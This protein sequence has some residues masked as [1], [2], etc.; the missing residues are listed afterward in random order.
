MK[1][2]DN[3][4]TEKILGACFEISNE[5]GSGF[6]ESVYK[7]ALVIVLTSLGQKVEEEIPLKVK[8]RGSLIGEFYADILFE[9]RVI[10]ELKAIKSLTSEHEA[11]LLNDLKATGLKV[12]LLV[13]FGKTKVEWKRLVY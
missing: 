12:G 6:L 8:F 10:V 3:D 9:G 7:K 4:L 2:L 11:Q 1:L 5:R 13:N